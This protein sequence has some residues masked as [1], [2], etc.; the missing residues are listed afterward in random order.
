MKKLVNVQE[1]EDAGLISLLG[2]QVI[3]FCVNYFYSGKLV[4]VNDT[5]VELENGHIVYETGAFTESKWKDAQKVA[6][7]LFVQVAAIESFAR[8]K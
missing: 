8:G 6:D 2:E 3:L 7:N 5:C 1:V 4:G